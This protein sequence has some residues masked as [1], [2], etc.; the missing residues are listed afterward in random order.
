MSCIKRPSS[1]SNKQRG[2]GSGI[3][4]CGSI[5]LLVHAQIVREGI[6]GTVSSLI[7]CAE[8]DDTIQ[9]SNGWELVYGGEFIHDIENTT[10]Y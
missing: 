6:V 2:V 4:G 8:V 10:K 3:F 5:W 9:Q 7:T 1:I